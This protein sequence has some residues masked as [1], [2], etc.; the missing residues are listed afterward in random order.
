MKQKYDMIR[1]KLRPKQITK[2]VY[3]VRCQRCSYKWDFGGKNLYL[4]TCPH[5]GTKVSLRKQILLSQTQSNLQIHP[6]S[7]I[8]ETRN[9]SDK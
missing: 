6:E 4:A 7:V 2:I 5:C 8:A 9:H 1:E 3:P